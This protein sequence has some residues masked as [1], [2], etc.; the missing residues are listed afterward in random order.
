MTI[1]EELADI[2][3]RLRVISDN[4][5]AALHAYSETIKGLEKTYL[6]QVSQQE[7]IAKLMQ[8]LDKIEN[9]LV[10]DIDDGESWKNGE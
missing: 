2:R 6:E 1:P 10:D 8:A 4:Q 5:D 7:A 9:K 3:R